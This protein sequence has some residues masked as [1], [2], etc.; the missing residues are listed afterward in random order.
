[1]QLKGVYSLLYNWCVV[2]KNTV[3]ER[4]KTLRIHLNKSHRMELLPGCVSC[5]YYRS[6]WADVRKHCL[7]L[8]KRD[9]DSEENDN[10]LWG[11]AQLDESKANPTYAALTED[12]VC[13][14]PLKGEVLAPLQV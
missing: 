7:R 13:A 14:Y 3:P 11:L 2:C 12:A 9:I 6:R 4:H 8:H 5:F 10:V 1:M